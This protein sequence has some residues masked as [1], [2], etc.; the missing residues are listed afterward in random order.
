VKCEVVLPTFP[1]PPLTLLGVPLFEELPLPCFLPPAA[2]PGF[3]PFLFF[4][5][6]F[7]NFLAMS[8]K[9]MSMSI[10]NQRESLPDAYNHLR[11]L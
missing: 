5:K 9:G 8:A 6:S 10:V 11:N 7:F 3:G 2:L 1:T 4:F